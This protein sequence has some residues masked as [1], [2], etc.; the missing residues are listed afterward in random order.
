MASSTKTPVHKKHSRISITSATSNALPQCTPNLMPFHIAYTGPAPVSTYFRVDDAKTQVGCPEPVQ[1]DAQA[2]TAGPSIES[3]PR[4]SDVAKSLSSEHDG[5]ISISESGTEQKLDGCGTSESSS[6]PIP[7]GQPRF[8]STFR[9]RVVQGLKVD[10]PEGYTGVV[11]RS[12]DETGESQNVSK[13]EPPSGKGKGKPT[14]AVQQKQGRTTRRSLRSRAVDDETMNIDA[15]E[16]QED[17]LNSHS[18]LNLAP[19]SKFESF[20]LWHPDIPVDTGRDEYMSAIGEWMRIA[21]VLH[22]APPGLAA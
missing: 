14:T 1:N 12:E 22:Q 20:V 18:T 11:F 4:D 5:I 21:S 16:Q 10:I 9:G 8:T 3:F 2:G 6:K 15:E 7:N 17:V 13:D 19:S